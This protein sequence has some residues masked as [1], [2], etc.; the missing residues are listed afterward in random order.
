M[1]KYMRRMAL[2]LACVVGMAASAAIPEAIQKTWAEMKSADVDSRAGFTKSLGV[3]VIAKGSVEITGSKAKAKTIARAN[4]L[5]NLAGFFGTQIESATETSTSESTVGEASEIREF[6]AKTTKTQVKQLLKGV[7][8]LAMDDDGDTMVAWIYLTTKA[9]DKT[10]ELKAAM[11]AMGDEGTVKAIGEANTH[12]NA[13]QM[14]L[15]AA[16][17]QVVGTM[18]VGET[19]ITDNEKVMSLMRESLSEMATNSETD[20][21][22][23]QLSDILQTPSE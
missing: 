2:L 13:V 1:G 19:K 4:A 15:R 16:V 10:E 22:G 8:D 3:Y 14:A 23:E 6:F 12:Q 20:I 17:E 11:A 5:E 21:V 9:Q 18:V 7:Q